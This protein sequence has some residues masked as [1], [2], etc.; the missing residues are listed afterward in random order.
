VRIYVEGGGNQRSTLNNCRQAFRLFLEKVVPRGSFEIIASGDRN[1]AFKDFRLALKQHPQ[2]YIILLVDSEEAVLGGPWPHLANRR[3]DHWNRPRGATDDQAHLMVQAMES[4]FLAD[5][6]VLIDYYG[7]GFLANALP[8][9]ANIEIVPKKDVFRAL[10][11][12][13]RNTAKK[14]EYH[15]TRHGF[16]LL[17]RIDPNRVR[18]ASLHADRL[19]L[20]LE[21]EAAA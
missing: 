17:E 5:R 3:G 1:K 7:Q 20:V 21:R 11:N 8:R 16:D 13:S 2:D 10:K 9:Q 4:W 12:A 19:F 15:K 18:H 14:G 6:Q